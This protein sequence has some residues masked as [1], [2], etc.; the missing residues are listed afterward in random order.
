[1]TGGGSGIGKG[2]CQRIAEE[3]ALVG[4]LDRRMQLAQEVADDICKK[5]G[6]AV[7]VECDVTDE[8][9]MEAS[10]NRIAKEFGGLYGMVAN[11]GTSGVGWIH[12]TRLED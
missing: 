3:G 10:I 2:T 11:A 1:M 6:Q 7:A 9:Q 5:G 4:V 8:A 12:E